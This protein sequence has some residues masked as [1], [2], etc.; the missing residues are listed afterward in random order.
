MVLLL[1][2]LLVLLG[3]NCQYEEQ[4]NTVNRMIEEVFVLIEFIFGKDFFRTILH[5]LNSKLERI[6]ICIFKK[7]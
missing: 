4:G 1:L 3:D 7:G 2:L 6:V 5:I